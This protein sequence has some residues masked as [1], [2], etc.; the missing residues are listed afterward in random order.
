MGTNYYVV[1][2]VCPHCNRGAD[3]IHIGKSSGG[4][5]FTVH[6][7][8]ENGINSW[9]DWHTFLKDKNIQDEYGRNVSLDEL[10]ELVVSKRMYGNA[11]HVIEANIKY[12]QFRKGDPNT[13]D[14]LMTGEFS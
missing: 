1:E 10:N 14:T 2:D 3:K 12:S 11:P 4:W 5:P 6:V 7:I 8:P 9:Q 13:G